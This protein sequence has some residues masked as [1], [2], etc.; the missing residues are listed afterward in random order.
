MMRTECIEGGVIT[1][2]VDHQLDQDSQASL[3]Q[4]PDVHHTK[5]TVNGCDRFAMKKEV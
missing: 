4:I 2:T 3:V 5:V 1:N